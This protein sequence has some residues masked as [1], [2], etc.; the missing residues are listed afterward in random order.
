[1][2][3][4]PRPLTILAMHDFLL[5]TGLGAAD[6]GCRVLDGHDCPYAWPIPRYDRDLRELWLGDA[7]IHC[8]A[9]QAKKEIA[10]VEMFEAQGWPRCIH[11]PLGDPADRGFEHHLHSVV[12][13]LNHG[14]RRRLIRFSCDAGARRVRWDYTARAARILRRTAIHPLVD[15]ERTR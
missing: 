8:F 4:H 2:A 9:P 13:E 3:G 15:D 7:L 11:D 1:M 14:Q 5:K 6:V 10:V 12:Y